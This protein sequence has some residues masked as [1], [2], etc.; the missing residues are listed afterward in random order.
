MPLA[1]H[2]TRLRVSGTAVPVTGEACGLVTG[3]IYRV[4][5]AARR[6]IDPATAWTVRD[7]GVAVAES[8]ILR[9]DYLFGIVEFTAAYTVTGPVTG[10][11]SFLPV[12]TIA[13]VR[14]F[15]ATFGPELQDST[16]FDSNGVRQKH[17]ALVDASGSLE[18]LSMATADLDAVAGGVQSLDSFLQN[19][20]PKLLEATLGASFFRAWVLLESV[21][22]TAEVAGLVTG[23]A[24]FS[25]ATQRAGAGLGFGT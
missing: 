10:D 8:N 12:A 3:K 22:T 1:G 11:F 20:T 7:N 4:T 6:I 17:P 23:T 16:T 5:N 14:S 18:F 24:N 15:S 9:R 2:T 21:E 19:A 25:L 13:E